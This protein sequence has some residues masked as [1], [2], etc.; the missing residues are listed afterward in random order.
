MARKNVYLMQGKMSQ[1]IKA[2]F[3]MEAKRIA[4]KRAMLRQEF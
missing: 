3:P 2:L 1:D 4:F